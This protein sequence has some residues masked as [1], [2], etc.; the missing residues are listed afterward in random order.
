MVE[1]EEKERREREILDKAKSS[2]QGSST[3]FGA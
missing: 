1:E 2:I 3:T